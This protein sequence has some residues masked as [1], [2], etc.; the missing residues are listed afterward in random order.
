MVVHWFSKSCRIA[1]GDTSSAG[2]DL[3]IAP[4]NA[5]AQTAHRRRQTGRVNILNRLNGGGHHRHQDLRPHDLEPTTNSRKETETALRQKRDENIN[6]AWLRCPS[7][8][9]PSP[10]DF[11][12][13][14]ST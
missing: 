2:A 3:P 4:A 10:Y 1:G 13:Q 12:Q 11:V 14:E 5:A 8:I 6:Y 9:E 7:Q